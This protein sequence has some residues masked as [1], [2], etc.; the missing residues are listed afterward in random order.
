M[1]AL[2]RLTFGLRVLGFR[3]ILISVAFHQ[4]GILPSLML[5][6][7][8]VGTVLVMRPWLRRIQLP[9]YARISVILCTVSLIMVGAVVV[10]PGMPTHVAWGMAY[11]PVVVLGMLAEGVARTA[12]RED[13]MRAGWIAFTTVA[14]AL[15][16]TLICTIPALQS[17]VLRCPEIAL[18]EVVAVIAISEF[19]DLRLLQRRM[20]TAHDAA[21]MVAPGAYRVAVV[22]NRLDPSLSPGARRRALALRSVQKIV[23]ALRRRDYA[24][25]VMEGDASLLDELQRFMPADGA[26]DGDAGLVLNLAH[27]SN[28]ADGA[29]HVPALLEMSGFSYSGPTPLGHAMT[30]DRLLAKV[31]MQQAAIPTPAFRLLGKPRDDPGGLRFPAIVR[32]RHDP[33]AR[34]ISVADAR[35]LRAA[36]RRCTRRHRQQ[37]FAEELVVG[38]QIS[39]ALIGNDPIKCLP[40]VEVDSEGNA[41]ICPAPLP[42]KT[43]ERIREH[44]RAAFRAC[45]CRDYA[46][47]DVRVADPAHVWVLEVRTLGILARHGSFVRAGA[48][49]GYSFD[50]LI[51]RI[52]E[53]ARARCAGAEAAPSRRRVREVAPA[54]AMEVVGAEA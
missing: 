29:T 44:A 2:V 20:A 23:D 43:A 6:A 26:P 49:A 37:A 48:E 27:G 35:Q 11:F 8:A 17:F 46:R 31:L 4:S 14:L 10:G 13:A 22:R 9:Y 41:R 28:G 45:G 39:V 36:V 51:G 47:V 1:V 42:E 16:M 25:R 5:I 7:L 34:P 18:T 24:V 53:V 40:L 30:F 54:E 33:S 21:R 3:S 50:E 15:V 32:P 19:L 52:V 38:R 12:D